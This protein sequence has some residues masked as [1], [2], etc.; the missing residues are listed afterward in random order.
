MAANVLLRRALINTAIALIPPVLM[1]SLYQGVTPRQ[2]WLSFL[3]S[4]V[5]SHLIGSLAFTAIPRVWCAAPT[6]AVWVQWLLRTAAVFAIALTGSMLAAFL[7]VLLRGL[8]L[9]NYWAELGGSLKIA[10]LI[11]AGASAVV[12]M[13]ESFRSRLD[14]TTL[15][16][17]NKELER[18]R[19]LKLATE[20]Q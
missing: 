11:T 6:S 1:L 7:V 12:S 18:E 17:R 3:Y 10:V 2:L 4:L 9:A 15:E 13:Y 5:Y 14:Q 20:A 16:L 8:P 19:A